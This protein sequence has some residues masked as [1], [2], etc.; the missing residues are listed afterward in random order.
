MVPVSPYKSRLVSFSAVTGKAASDPAQTPG[1]TGNEARHLSR[2]AFQCA[3]GAESTA[4]LNLGGYA[5]SMSTPQPPDPKQPSTGTIPN[6]AV[7]AYGL[8]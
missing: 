4:Y 7:N 2:H 1:C 8:V 6:L 5:C 3:E